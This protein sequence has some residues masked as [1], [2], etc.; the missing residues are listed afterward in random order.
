MQF[1]HYSEVNLFWGVLCG[2]RAFQVMFGLVGMFYVYY[3]MLSYFENLNPPY[4]TA[5]FYFGMFEH[6][7]IYIYGELKCCTREL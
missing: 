1:K 7:I 2:V 4:P 3:Y 6:L 5:A